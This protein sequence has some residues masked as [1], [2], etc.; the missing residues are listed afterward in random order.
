MNPP[1][2]QYPNALEVI[3]QI[4]NLTQGEDCI[5][6]GESSI[7]FGYPCS[8]T[9]YR[10]LKDEGF[11]ERDIPELLKE[12]Q[13]EL[14]EKI[15]GY[16]TEGE[17]DL[18]RLMACQH[19]GGKTNLLDFSGAIAVALYFTCFKDSDDDGRVIVKQKNTFCKLK[20]DNALPG[21]KIV[22]LEPPQKLKRAMDQKGVLIHA[23][24]GFLPFETAETVAIKAEWKQE[25]LEHIEKEY[26]ISYETIFDDMQGAIELQRQ[27]DKKRVATATQST[28]GIRGFVKPRDGEAI[29]AMEYYMRLLASA[30][31]GFYKDQLNNQANVL[32]KSFT[33]AI[34]RDPQDAEAYYNRAFVHQSKSEPDYERAISDYTRSLE[35]DPCQAG[36][37]NNRGNAYWAKQSPDYEKAIADYNQ[38]IQLNQS[39]GEAY[40]NRGNVY[41][42]KP[43]PDYVQALRDYNQAITLNPNYAEAYNN[44][45]NVYSGMPV[46]DYEKALKNYDRALALNPTYVDAYYNRGLAYSEM[47]PPNDEKALR[48]YGKAIALNPRHTSAY[49][50]RGNVYSRKNPPNYERALEDF[51]RAIILNP[52]HA[53]AYCNRASVYIKKV[54]PN[55]RMALDDC[56]RAITLNPGFAVAYLTR[57]LACSSMSSPDRDKIVK[58]Y[59]K[60]IELK[61]DLAEAYFSR[62]LVYSLIMPFRYEE[63]LKDFSQAINLS[64]PNPK[65]YYMRSLTYAKLGDCISARDDY[66]TAVDQEPELKFIDLIPELKK[67]LE[68]Q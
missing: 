22:L 64:T 40:N 1:K 67:C 11:P 2:D 35:I 54:P 51:N 14:I 16:A 58:D 56:N 44:R 21:D 6:R 25:I 60:A 66:K 13:G 36:A 31:V 45:G 27:E 5:Y 63:A 62:G 10:Q 59:N 34:T 26:G 3:R 37:F 7:N 20:T 61:P 42:E 57:G 24:K 65:G 38:A 39:L 53:N 8:S 55:Y 43:N 48:D 68:S 9:L 41:R 12:R 19:K 32:I 15:R 47:S 52:N 33:D 18:E 50:N 30:V 29:L 23:P 49:N 4:T 46:A 17:N 28:T